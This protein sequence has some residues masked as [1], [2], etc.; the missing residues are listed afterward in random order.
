MTT[1]ST[2][3]FGYGSLISSQSR[4]HTGITGVAI[5]CKYEG[6]KRSWSLPIISEGVIALN[7]S[8][9][10]NSNCNGVLIEIDPKELPKFDE[11]EREYTRIKMSLDNITL[12]SG[13]SM[14]LLNNTAVWAYTLQNPPEIPEDFVI[15]QSYVDV[16]ISGC[17]EWGTSFT[18]TFVETTHGWKQPWR[19]DR[20][21]PTYPRPLSKDFDTTL[22]DPFVENFYS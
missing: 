6:L 11:R 14:T 21:N 3:M 5:P 19:M 15:E 18:K 4:K 2:Y 12:E 20:K 13:N 10:T 9:D 1:N 7:I 17:L 16:I 8:E 22:I